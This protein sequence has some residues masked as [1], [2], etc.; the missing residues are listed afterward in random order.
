LVAIVGGSGAGKTW[1]ADR[2]HRLLGEKGGR[3]SLDDFYH[4]Q[5]LLAP[6][7]RPQLNFDRPDAIEWPLFE[8]VLQNYAAGRLARV[9]H[10]DF[11]TH[12]RV[13]GLTPVAPRPVVLVEGLWL[14]QPPAIRRLFSLKIFLE[15]PEKVRLRRR[16]DRDVKERGRSPASVRR[17]FRDAVAPMHRRHVEPQARWADLVLRHP[18]TEAGIQQLHEAIWDLLKSSSLMPAWMRETFRAEL[19]TLLKNHN[20]PS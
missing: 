2:L 18:H 13:N 4:D 5:S 6:S 12:C 10:Y 7:K 15:C 14:L 1:L 3:L 16:L 20:P 17:Q 8:R 9:P 19:A 11:Q